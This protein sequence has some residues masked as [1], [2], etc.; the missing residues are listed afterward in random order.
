MRTQF[1]CTFV[2]FR[3]SDFHSESL[4]SS[5]GATNDPMITLRENISRDDI[6]RE[7]RRPVASTD[8]DI[9]YI[10]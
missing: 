10:Y 2:N 9:M 7:F 6:D 1:N 4:I 8:R 3:S 5:Q